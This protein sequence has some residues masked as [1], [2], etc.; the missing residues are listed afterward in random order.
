MDYFD[1]LTQ[2]MD[3]LSN[4]PKTIFIGQSC[5]WDGHALFKTMKN[6]PQDQRIETPVFEDF[7]MGISNGLAIAGFVPVNIYPRFDFLL[8]ATNQMFNHQDNL[9]HWSKGKSKAKVIT[10]VCVGTKDP[11]DPGIQH[12]QDYTESFK[13]MSK[14]INIVSLSK[15]SM[16]T[17][18]YEKALLRDDGISTVLIEYADLYHKQ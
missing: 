18:E 17:D 6:V 11:L 3:Y 14:T 9:L 5:V 7:Q 15:S 16:I 12:C 1:K 10:R 8:L 4:N 2:S 13:G